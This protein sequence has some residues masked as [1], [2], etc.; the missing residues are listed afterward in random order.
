MKIS[1]QDLKTPRQW[2][3]ALGYDAHHF[4]QLLLVFR[5]AYE[6]LNEM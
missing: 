3:A 4:A 5:R 1:I 6:A 2:R